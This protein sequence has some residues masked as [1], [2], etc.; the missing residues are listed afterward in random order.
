MAVWTI[1][2]SL[3]SGSS[4]GHGGLSRGLHSEDQPFFISDILFL[5]RAEV[6]LWMSR[7]F[8]GRDCVNSRLLLTALLAPL[9]ID[10][11]PVDHSCAPTPVTTVSCL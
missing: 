2:T 5:F 8:E 4:I 10:V 6:I 1:D 7:V 3:A 9:I 11:L